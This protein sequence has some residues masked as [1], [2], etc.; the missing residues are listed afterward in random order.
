MFPF[1]SLAIECRMLNW[2]V[3]VPRSPH[4]FTQRPFLSTFT[5]RELL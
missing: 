3:S 1:A 5:T 2:L 4:V